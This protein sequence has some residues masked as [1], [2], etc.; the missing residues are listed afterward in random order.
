MNV[1]SRPHNVEYAS[2]MNPIPSVPIDTIS[3]PLQA[4]GYLHHWLVAGPQALAVTDLSGFDRNQ[5]QAQI[6]ATYHQPTHPVTHSPAELTPL[7]INDA[8]GAA[9][10]TWRAVR[11]GD[12]HFIDCTSFYHTCHYLRTWAY[13]ELTA[14]SAVDA[15][16]VL[17]SHGPADVWINGTLVHQHS[18]FHRKFLPP[19]TFM[20][21]LQA[22]RNTVLICFTTVAIRDCPY[23]LALQVTGVTPE[24][25]TVQ[26]PTTLPVK[27]RQA[28][29]AIF[30]AAYLDQEI[31][32]RD[33]ELIVRWPADFTLA[34]EITIRVQTPSGRIYTEGHPSVRGGSA[35]KL[36]KAYQ[37]PD[38]A[39]RVT[40]MP[41][42]EDYHVHG[43]RI[44]RHIPIHIANGKFAE[45]SYGTYAERRAEALLDASGRAGNIYSEIAKM[46][47]GRWDKLTLDRFTTTLAQIN[48]RADCS[49]FYLV[50]LLGA[51]LRYGADPAF[52]ATLKT[53]IE[54]CALNFKYWM[55]EP[56]DDAMCYWSENHQILFHAC[57]VLAGQLFPDQLF[58]NVKQTGRWHQRKGEERALSWLRKRA[59]GGFREW[60]SN[61]YFEHDVLALSH[62]ADLADNGE[63]AEMATVVLDKLFFTM[64]LNS[65][66]GVFGS[67]HGRTY[68]PYIKSGR[69]ELTSGLSRLLWGVGAFNE[70]ILGV[71]SL[72]CAPSYELP[73]PIFEIGA[74]PVE[75]LWSKE[76]HAGVMEA[77][78]DL[79]QD[80]W[81]VNKVT[82]KTP[83]Y[84]LCSA[85]DYQPG[86][87]GYQQHIWQATL[88][89]DAVVFVNH[90]P[91]VSQEGSHRPNFWHGNGILPRVA[92]WKDVLVA[93]HNLPADDWLGFTHA[94]FPLANFDETV[95]HDG[96]AF[97]RKGNGYLALT[98][99]TGFTLTTTGD[100]AYRE[101]RAYG[102]QQG[103]FCHL[104]RTATDGSFAEFQSK[105]LALDLTFA[106]LALHGTTLRGESV[107]FGWEG[108]LLIN[109]REQPL[110]DFRH[111]DSPFC[112]SEVGAE[113]MEIRAWQQAMQLNFRM[114]LTDS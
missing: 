102:Q 27:R 55:D 61:V 99:M 38:G 63:L 25:L 82:Y 113:V 77:W 28:L 108:P 75:E 18:H 80:A 84:M 13:T 2:T 41:T 76:R 17:T 45:T 69:L 30:D 60:D 90:P 43:F 5:L 104:G 96:W 34:G 67:T 79:G 12:D 54:Q 19:Q 53:Q 85:Q 65:F 20:A 33:D 74:T 37:R 14:A 71:V 62:L 88:G 8:H 95:M 6:A 39:Y 11:C 47:L 59:E 50:G 94:Y 106:P 110:T 111:Y 101:L 22:G 91:C 26:L 68:A 109:E 89:P 97:A 48:Q 44:L 15:T 24:T 1:S 46:A 114:G 93:L 98:A 23:A 3:Y 103:W 83:D 21:P 78:C 31:Y 16:F 58:S 57:Q 81:E 73:P 66:R 4:Q 87:P 72:A 92:Q 100:Q 40:L 7:T 42:A 10:L 107:D 29:E 64:A 36:G 70:H 49:D 56:G 52:P 86:L 105:I 35:I 112:V 51:L 9:T 32:H